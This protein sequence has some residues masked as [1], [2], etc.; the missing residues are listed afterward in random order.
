MNIRSLQEIKSKQ[1]NSE[2]KILVRELNDSMADCVKRVS[3][4][5]GIS[6]EAAGVLVA[7]VLD[8]GDVEK[9]V[10]EILHGRPTGAKSRLERYSRA[11]IY[12]MGAALKEL[13]GKQTNPDFEITV[14]ILE[15]MLKKNLIKPIA[16]QERISEEAS[17]ILMT[18]A[19][20]FNKVIETIELYCHYIMTGE[21][22]L[23]E[24][25]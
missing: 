23:P 6:E 8:Y 1:T 9:K 10:D 14:P 11:E 24:N 25:E 12:R 18:N 19:F 22:S 3:K 5:Q 16:K 15:D 7:N 2:S 13:I 20:Y 21:Q 17:E 4:E